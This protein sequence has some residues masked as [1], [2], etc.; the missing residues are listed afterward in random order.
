MECKAAVTTH[1]INTHLMA[2]ELLPNIQCS[3]ES[4]SFV[5]EMRSLKMRSIAADRQKLTM[6]N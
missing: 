2:Q 5:K 3:G 1:D 6:T 4:R